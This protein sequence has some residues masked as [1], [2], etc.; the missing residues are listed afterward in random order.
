MENS[1]YEDGLV[2]IVMPVYNAEDYVV[3]AIKCLLQ[4]TY[5][6]IEIIVVDDLSTDDSL[7]R[8]KELIDSRIHVYS[9]DKNIGPANA[10]NIGIRHAKG[11]YLAYMDA[12]DLCEP[13]KIEKQIRFMK[14]RECAFCFTGYEFADETGKRTG[15]VVNVPAEVDYE[16]A[17]RH[18]IISTIT[19]MFDRE[20]IPEELLYMPLDAR[21]EDTATWWQILRHGYIAYSINEPLSAYRRHA[22]TRSSNKLSAVYGTWRMYRKNEQ[23]GLVKSMVCFCSYVI[24]AIKRRV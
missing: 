16:Y 7:S 6:D 22:N 3:E 15:K 20:K 4:Q 10:R 23:L 11:R 17:L 24:N 12:D 9:A 5:Q 19:V 21:G 13:D 14:V 8:I 2:S 1:R 18:T